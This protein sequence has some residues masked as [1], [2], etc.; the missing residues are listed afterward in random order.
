MSEGLLLLTN[1][2]A[3]AERLLHPRYR[4]E[5]RYEVTVAGPLAHDFES[6][7]REG[8]RLEDGWV[9]AER[10]RS[11]PGPRADQAVVDLT[12]REGRNREVRRLME[13]LGLTIHALKRVSY[14][15][16]ELG[17]LPRGEFRPLDAGEL[18][19]LRETTGNE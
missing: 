10:V 9:R 7:L 12:L 14:G 8:V 16:I 18:D 19:R 13:A 1:D 3:V 17:E 2:G 15:P 6:R 4:V 5:R 11:R